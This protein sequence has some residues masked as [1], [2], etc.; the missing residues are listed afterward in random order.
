M[1]RRRSR[2]RRRRCWTTSRWCSELFAAPLI[3]EGA[4]KLDRARRRPR[5]H[6]RPAP[7]GAAGRRRRPEH[8]RRYP[9]LQFVPRH[10]R[11]GSGRERADEHDAMTSERAMSLTSFAILVMIAMGAAAFIGSLLFVWLYVG[12]NILRRIGNLQSVM[13][14]LAQGDLAAEVM[15]SKTRDEVAEMAEVAGGVPREH[16]PVEDACRRAGQGPRRQGRAHRAHGS[17]HR[18][19][20]GDRALRPRHADGL[21]QRDADARR[22]R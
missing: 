6:L 4:A 1:P 18:Q 16:D 21:G 9:P 13:Q 15:A 19:L 8:P 7:Q 12:R 10:G 14:R 5:R 17:P 11:E 2:R 20:R 22:R 3:K